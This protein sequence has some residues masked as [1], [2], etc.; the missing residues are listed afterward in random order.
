MGKKAKK[1][2][3]EYEFSCEVKGYYDGYV[4]A[5]NKA[6]ALEKAEAELGYDNLTAVPGTMRVE[7]SRGQ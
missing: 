6:E 2:Q 1:R 4:K 7:R 3:N 5:A